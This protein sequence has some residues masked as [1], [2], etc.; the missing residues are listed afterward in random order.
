MRLPGKNELDRLGNRRDS[1]RLVGLAVGKDKIVLA[2][3]WARLPQL[4][5]FVE[6]IALLK[7]AAHQRGHW[8]TVPAPFAATSHFTERN[9]LSVHSAHAANEAGVPH[10]RERDLTIHADHECRRGILQANGGHIVQYPTMI[11]LSIARG[12]AK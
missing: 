2:G 3:A 6:R 12:L 10:V 4:H 8:Y 1:D 5:D 7:C 9:R 11:E